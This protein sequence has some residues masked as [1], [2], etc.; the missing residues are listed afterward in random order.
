MEF[1]S[2]IKPYNIPVTKPEITMT[3][4][5]DII[6]LMLI[7]FMVTTVFPENTGMIIQ[8][9][10]SE[11]SSTLKSESIIVKLNKNGK[12]SHKNTVISFSD[13]KRTLQYEIGK[14]PL[15]SIIIQADKDSTTDYLIKVIDICKSSGIKNIGVAT[16]QPKALLNSNSK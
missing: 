16:E 2:L 10:N 12:I 15:L 5:I 9:P 8:K 7:F 3:P 4:L 1:D 14:N 13:L 6:F 11:F